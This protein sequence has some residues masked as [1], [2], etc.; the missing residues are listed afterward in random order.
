MKASLNNILTRYL[1]LIVLLHYFFMPT[2]SIFLF[3]FYAIGLFLM[4]ARNVDSILYAILFF[5]PLENYFKFS[6]GTLSF[7]TIVI[8]LAMI[9]YIFKYWKA[10]K[11]NNIVFSFVAFI[12]ILLRTFFLDGNTSMILFRLII[13]F[14]II[15]ILGNVSKEKLIKTL[16][17]GIDYFVLGALSLCIVTCVRFV[18]TYG[19]TG[20]LNRRMYGFNGDDPNYMASYICIAMTF[21]I[22]K[23]IGKNG[24]YNKLFLVLVFLLTGILTQSRGFFLG[25]IPG[26]LFLLYKIIKNI[27]KIQV[28]VAITVVFVILFIERNYL[29]QLLDQVLTRFRVDDEVSS[30]RIIIWGNYLQ[31]FKNNPLEILWGNIYL[32][33][34]YHRAHNVIIGAFTEEGLLMAIVELCYYFYIKSQLK[35]KAL[36][37][38]GVIILASIFIV[39]QF[40]NATLLN[41]FFYSIMLEFSLVKYSVWKEKGLSV[42]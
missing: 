3:V 37:E 41:V 42:E 7:V 32:S 25:I 30:G 34:E 16:Y 18:N 23:D 24:K 13:N 35:V 38:R 21:V 27:N 33:N 8:I 36:S 40:I 2:G 5:L 29:F 19:F 10:I 22:I 9:L 14:N 4:V 28:L 17:N 15:L 11:I 31:Y 20:V 6:E 39:Y 26:I 1:L 12:V